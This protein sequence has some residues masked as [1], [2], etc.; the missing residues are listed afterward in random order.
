MKIW[1][2]IK[3]L[4]YAGIA[5]LAVMLVNMGTGC[6]GV[7]ASETTEGT[8]DAQT[9]WIIVGVIAVAVIVAVIIAAVTSVVSGVVGADEDSVN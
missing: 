7:L 8:L 2:R 9:A 6:A 1:K 4:V 3:A 5:L